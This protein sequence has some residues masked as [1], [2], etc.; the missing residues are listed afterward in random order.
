MRRFQ[1]LEVADQPW[2]PASV[3][4]AVTDNLR[5]GL[6]FFD[7][8]GP[9]VPHLRRALDRSG[10][11]RIVDLCSGGG[12]PWPGLADALDGETDA[13][14]R[15]C[16]TDRFPNTAA[17]RRIRASSASRLGFRGESVDA[18]APPADLP[19]F[20]TLFSSFHHFPPTEAR[21]ILADAVAKRQGIG[22]FEATRRAP[23]ALLIIV[24]LA[25][26][27]TLCFAPF[28]RP[29]RWSRLLWTYLVPL[30]P[31]VALIDGVVSCLRTYS[32]ADLRRLTDGLSEGGYVWETG[33]QP[34]SK[35]PV[36]ATYLI[37]YPMRRGV[38]SNISTSPRRR[39]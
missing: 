3:R 29:F 30:V 11:D 24:F 23:L 19:G 21:A 34:G 16:L 7:S 9:I 25:P 20:R 31:L 8:Y 15:V 12:G 17:F 6:E 18:L 36:P 5:F 32:P 38:R 4:D 1:L 39:C 2:C 37:G 26:L 33:E 35:L 14:V 10:E 13:P 27:A 22:V 28:I